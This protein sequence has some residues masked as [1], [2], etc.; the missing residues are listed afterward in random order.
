MI[1]VLFFARDPGGANVIIPVYKKMEGKYQRLIYAKEFAYERIKKEGIPVI[2]IKEE[3]GDKE[4]D[5][6]YFL[7]RTNPQILITGTSLNDYTERYLWKAAE[8]LGIKSYAI[9]DQWMNLGIR[10]SD[11]NYDEIEKYRKNRVHPF[12]PSRI[13][14]MDELAK[15]SIVQDGIDEK[16]IAIT[17][18]PH[19]DVIC[20]MYEQA[21]ESY[22]KKCWNIVFASEPISHDY[23]SD[24]TEHLYWGYNERTIFTS[25]YKCVMK[26]GDKY[27]IK[28]RIIIR[29]HPREDKKNWNYIISEYSNENMIIECNDRD[30]SFSIL[31]SM[32]VVCGI[33]SMFLL[34][35][36]I[37]KKDVISIEIGLRQKNPFILDQMKI[38]K[39][40]LD[41]EKLL[42]KLE[43]ILVSQK[44]YTHTEGSEFKY[45]KNATEKVIL[46]I[47]KEMA[48]W[49]N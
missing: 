6:V 49:V 4:E 2:N 43:K 10:F 21:K 22:D 25:L 24:S 1:T 34:E 41:E 12:L 17:G 47:E 8:E 29:P 27:G 38:C 23:D 5:I 33:S 20:D 35:A 18:Q 13:L 11:Y 46:F 31:K 28:S 32:D 15:E 44:S 40:V 14:V 39:S 9:L 19:F 26:L 45:I 42:C 48:A 3:C 7:K 37:C 16:R 36:F 30:D